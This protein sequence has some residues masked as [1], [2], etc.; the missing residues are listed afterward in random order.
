MI[1]RLASV[2][3]F[4]YSISLGVILLDFALGAIMTKKMIKIE[5]KIT[6]RYFL[7]VILFF[8]THAICR[9][10]FFLHTFIFNRQLLA[11]FFIGTILGLL[12][13][14]FIVEAVETLIFKKTK[15]I[16]TMYGIAGLIAMIV[17][18]FFDTTI[19]G[20]RLIVWIQ[21]FTVPVLA[22]VMVLLYFIHIFKS[23]GS[24]RMHFILMTIGIVAIALG[25]MGNTSTAHLLLPW[26][27]W[28]APLLMMLGLIIIYVSISKYYKEKY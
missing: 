6:K 9:L 12:C 8:F 18:S 1:K 24:I 27:S 2:D 23:S 3:L 17:S 14:I 20:L 16:F 26:T 5:L 15:H 25:E 21:Y 10:I 7:G 28:G 13:E 11:L 22:L 19:N 4:V